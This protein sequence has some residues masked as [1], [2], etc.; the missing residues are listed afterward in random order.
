MRPSPPGSTPA[1]GHAARRGPLVPVR[2]G[3]DDRGPRYVITPT[4]RRAAKRTVGVFVLYAGAGRVARTHPPGPRLDQAEGPC[5]CPPKYIVN[6]GRTT[7]PVNGLAEC[8][9]QVP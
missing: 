7:V 3:C 5:R 9:M 2:D 8:A 4:E 1:P 6:R